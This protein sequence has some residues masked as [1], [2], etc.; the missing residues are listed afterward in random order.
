MGPGARFAPLCLAFPHPASPRWLSLRLPCP[1]RGLPD[2][3]RADFG[4]LGGRHGEGS[5][6]RPRPAMPPAKAGG[7]EALVL[8]CEWQVCTYVASKME[9][10]CEH[11]AQHLQQHL[12]GEERDE[13]DP[14]G[15]Q[16]PSLLSEVVHC[17]RVFLSQRRAAQPVAG[18][19]S[20]EKSRGVPLSGGT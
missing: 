15:K 13:M 6:R 7:K 8:Q 18:L 12:P 10:F 16:L 5:P 1:G 2:S 17:Q 20:H 4:Q 9:E 11:V 3:V 14:L 19:D